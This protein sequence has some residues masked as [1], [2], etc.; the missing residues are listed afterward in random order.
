VLLIIVAASL[1]LAQRANNRRGRVINAFMN[2][3]RAA[4]IGVNVATASTPEPTLVRSAGKRPLAQLPGL[5]SLLLRAGVTQHQRWVVMHVVG[6]ALA[7]TI[8]LVFGGWIAASAAVFMVIAL[9]WFRLFYIISRRRVRI[10]RQLPGFLDALIRQV[11][12][13][14]SL[15]SAFQQVAAQTPMPLG[16]LVTRSAQLNRAGIEFDLAVK[17]IALMYKIDELYM[18][19]A[20][21]GVSTK[22][23]GRTDQVL[24]RI[25]AFIRDFE[26]A[27]E[28]LVA[29]SAET[30]MSAWILGLL[31]LCVCG[32]IV[33]FNNNFYST[34]LHDP[35]GVKMLTVA[36]GLQI[37]GSFG[38]YR[39]AKS[40]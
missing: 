3:H 28:E 15:G 25:A 9:S 35:T 16:E 10:V 37:L 29:M 32:I 34:M 22:Y 4:T 33:V 18:I 20:V 36:G 31:P 2:Q 26:Q 6:V 19:G 13:G 30:R 8:A 14:T 5:E 27:Q 17:Q 39:L 21:I 1:L 38:L 11:T 7:G 12:V 23:G 40:I 24:E